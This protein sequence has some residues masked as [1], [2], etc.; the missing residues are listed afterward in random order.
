MAFS[1]PTVLALLG[2]IVLFAPCFWAYVP[3]RISW[4]RSGQ[5]CSWLEEKKFGA[6]TCSLTI[7]RLFA[8]NVVSKS[9]E[10]ILR[11]KFRNAAQFCF[12]VRVNCCVVADK[13]KKAAWRSLGGRDSVFF[14]W[15][16]AGTIV[17]TFRCR[18]CW[19]PIDY[20]GS[21]LATLWFTVTDLMKPQKTH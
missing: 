11:K 15:I 6:K 7:F 16:E 2:C 18:T 9:E 14:C 12:D 10:T 8:R 19:I 4:T 3:F 1:C 5:S 13:Y 17:I 21:M 20:T